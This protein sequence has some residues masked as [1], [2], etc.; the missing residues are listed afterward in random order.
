MRAIRI[1]S[2]YG[3]ADANRPPILPPR[4][5]KRI[6]S[7]AAAS[8]LAVAGFAGTQTVH[9]SATVPIDTLPR[10][11][12]V[13][14]SY[15]TFASFQWFDVAVGFTVPTFGTIERITTALTARPAFGPFYVGIASN[16]LIGNPAVPSYF[17][18]PPGSLVDFVVC[19]NVPPWD[20]DE[21]GCDADAG[22]W[23]EPDYRLGAGEAL[24]LSL[25]LFLPRAGTY[26][27]Y[28][29]FWRDDVFA[30]WT[31]NKSI[32]TGL[33]ATRTGICTGESAASCDSPDDRTFFLVDQPRDALGLRVEFEPG[34]RISEPGTLAL[35]AISM[36]GLVLRRRVTAK[37]RHERMP[38][39]LATAY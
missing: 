34:R 23:G 7:I 32:Q 15:E 12:D 6:Q 9:A 4:R 38:G 22:A 5:I 28:T 17:D 11:G 33:I 18:P 2:K 20:V 21:S 27:I 13:T 30:D 19:S 14:G 8:V 35:L 24:D 31:T 25:D 16:E 3:D 39:R 37:R 26:W 10:P 1:V 29:R 36:V